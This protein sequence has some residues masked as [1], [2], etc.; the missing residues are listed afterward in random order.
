MKTA[1]KANKKMKNTSHFKALMTQLSEK[2]PMLPMACLK[3]QKQLTWV[4]NWQ[5]DVLFQDDISI[6][7]R[8]KQ[9]LENVRFESKL[10]LKH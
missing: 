8:N 9:V 2:Q 4:W 10:H 1:T 3:T 5:P 7:D 6:K